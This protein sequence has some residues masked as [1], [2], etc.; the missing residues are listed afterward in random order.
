[1]EKKNYNTYYKCSTISS[2]TSVNLYNLPLRASGFT[3]SINSL[4]FNSL[5]TLLT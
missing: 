5:N 4:L 3:S 2:P 1:M